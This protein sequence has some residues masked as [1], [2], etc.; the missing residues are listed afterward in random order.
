MILI[1]LETGELDQL[2]ERVTEILHEKNE[3]Y[4]KVT[5]GL[6]DDLNSI[7]EELMNE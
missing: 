7:S 3:I 2:E 4:S 5:D 6:V 1:I